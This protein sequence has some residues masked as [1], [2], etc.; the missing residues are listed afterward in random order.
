MLLCV[1]NNLFTWVHSVGLIK[2]E[3]YLNQFFIAKLVPRTTGLN[4]L[5]N[6][7]TKSL[8]FDI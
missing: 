6:T 4:I 1:L 5:Q 7:E 3:K 8:L 2:H